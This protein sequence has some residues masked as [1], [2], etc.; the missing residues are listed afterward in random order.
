[1]KLPYI[2]ALASIGLT[3]SCATATVEQ[4]AKFTG[5]LTPA[6]MAEIGAFA[7]KHTG[8][9]VTLAPTD[10]TQSDTVVLS[11]VPAR[12]AQG[13]LLDGRVREPVAEVLRLT[14]RGQS[15]VVT[16]TKSG[17]QVVLHACGSFVAY[18]P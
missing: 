14:S 13:R 17:A 12:D 11:Q 16:H 1:M 4:P 2:A 7:S 5:N 10:F 8:R 18:K 3:T 6:C 9:M 15:C